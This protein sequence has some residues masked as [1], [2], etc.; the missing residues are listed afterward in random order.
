MSLA[1]VPVTKRLA[2]AVGAVD[3]PDPDRRIHRQPTPRLGG[4]ALFAGFTVALLFF[5]GPVS[6]RWQVIAV[7]AVVTIA[8]AVDDILH[9]P[10]WTKLLIEGGVGLFVAAAGITITFFALPGESVHLI[11]LGWLAIPVTAVWVVGMQTSINLLDGSD[12]VAA[13]V[14]GIVAAICL[15]AAI[16]RVDEPGGIQNG[17]IVLSGALMGCCAGFLVFNF[18]PASVFMGDGG[19]HFLGV[20]LA[21]ITVLGVAKVAVA[22]SLFVPLITL[23]LPIGDTAFAIVR[24]RRAGRSMAQPDTE[25]I[26]HRLLARGM[27]P[28]E[29]ACTFYFAT[30]ILGCISLWIF[31]HRRIVVVGVV[32]FAV[33]LVV[34]WWRHRKRIASYEVDAEG[35]LIIPGTRATPARVRHRGEI[36]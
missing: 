33:A 31:G 35:Y 16:N 34:L 5:G 29:T 21:V 27:T 19:S 8:M 32:L 11:Q 24:R 22:L 10:W 13:G 28:L 4:I 1:L 3:Q 2:L 12:G 18:P 36:D 7:S 15:I 30:A 14:V 26:H 6:D 9:L 20:A 23:A 25:H 17:V